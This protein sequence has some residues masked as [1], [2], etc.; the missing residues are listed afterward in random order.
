M[1]DQIMYLVALAGMFLL[2]SSVWAQ[3]ARKIVDFN[4]STNTTSTGQRFGTYSDKSM[5]GTSTI[6]MRKIEVAAGKQGVEIT[7]AITNDYPYGFAGLHFPL[8][9]GDAEVM[10]VS[11]FTGVRFHARGD[12]Q[13]FYLVLVTKGIKDYDYLTYLFTPSAEWK[14][15]VVPFSKLKQLGFG[16]PAKWTGKDLQAVRFQ[17]QTF[18]PPIANYKLDVDSIELY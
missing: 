10:D 16:A 8:V 11:Q 13:N 9:P 1:K 18:G 3:T 14:D 12:G 15:Y 5:K 4:A 7:G 6:A 2:T 17:I